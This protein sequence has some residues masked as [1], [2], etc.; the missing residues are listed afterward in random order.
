M[1]AAVMGEREDLDVPSFA[2]EPVQ[3]PRY[4]PIPELVRAFR[5]PA[6]TAACGEPDPPY[7]QFIADDYL[8]LHLFLD[9]DAAAAAAADDMAR[10]RA[11]VERV[12]HE[13]RHGEAADKLATLEQQL[14]G[15]KK[16]H[17]AVVAKQASVRASIHATL[18]K[19]GD[20]YIM[21]KD[22]H[23]LCIREDSLTRRIAA[24]EKLVADARHQLKRFI[25]QAVEAAVDKARADVAAQQQ[26]ALDEAAA[27][28]REHTDRLGALHHAENDLY[29][30]PGLPSWAEALAA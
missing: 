5:E 26:A 4:D 8:C 18:A 24:L 30:A 29:G 16:E 20:V 27:A 17:E 23:D 25:R 19:G 22:Y 9:P 1:A 15:A 13:A 7:V 6:P 11:D 10:V 14:T 12:A 2:P 3:R 28:L 21:E